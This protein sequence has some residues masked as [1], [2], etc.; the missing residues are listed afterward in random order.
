MT[1]I[2]CVKLDGLPS[3]TTVIWNTD[4]KST[5]DK[6]GRHDLH[7]SLRQVILLYT[8]LELLTRQLYCC[9]GRFVSVRDKAVIIAKVF[10]KI[11]ARSKKIIIKLILISGVF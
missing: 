5:E 11:N 4:A 10:R 2:E 6:R 7:L 9:A 8:R 1:L 3:S